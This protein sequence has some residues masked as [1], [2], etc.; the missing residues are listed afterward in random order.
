MYFRTHTHAH[1]HTY[2][3]TYTHAHIHMHTYACTHTH[4]THTYAHIYTRILDPL[5]QTELRA[6]SGCGTDFLAKFQPIIMTST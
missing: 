5:I 1:M 4:D 2:T 3:R 6:A